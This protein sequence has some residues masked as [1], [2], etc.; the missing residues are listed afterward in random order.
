VVEVLR[1]DVKNL[2]YRI[3]MVRSGLECEKLSS[4]TDVSATPMGR[5]EVFLPS[6]LARLCLRGWGT[7]MARARK[8]YI[9]V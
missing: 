1:S 8:K 3:S 2:G 6:A 5:D 9:Q 7:G 4:C